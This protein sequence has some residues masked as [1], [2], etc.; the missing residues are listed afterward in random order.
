MTLEFSDLGFAPDYVD[1]RQAWHRQRELHDAV[2]ARTAPDTILLLEHAS[3]YTAGKRTEA[4]ER[5]FDGTPVV[6]VDR[7]GKLTWHGPGQLVGYPIIRL[8]DPHAIREYV[9]ILEDVLIATLAEYGV[10]GERV[11]GRA[12]IWLR[13]DTAEND[14]LKSQDRKIAS[15]GIR[16]HNGVAM[17]GFALNCNNDLAPFAQIIACGISDAGA[18]TISRETGRDVSP[19]EVAAVVRREVALREAELIGHAAADQTLPE[20]ALS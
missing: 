2:V 10:T 17:H 12:G 9:T 20:G 11:E 18:T 13:A 7:G 6:D 4:H 16:V 3:V 8:R 1:Y 19:A 15:I 14:S 5:P